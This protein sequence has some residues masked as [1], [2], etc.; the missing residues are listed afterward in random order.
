MLQSP[1]SSTAGKINTVAVYFDDPSYD[2]YPFDNEEYRISYHDLA[3]AIQQRGGRFAIVRGQESYIGNRTFS[4]GWIYDGTTFRASSEPL[5]CDIIYNKGHFSGDG[6]EIILNH[7]DLDAICTDKVRTYELLPN[8][9]PKTVCVAGAEMLPE[10]LEVLRTDR[11]VGKPTHGEGGHDVHIGSKDTVAQMLRRFP[12][13]LQEYVDTSG[14][15]PKLVDGLHD[16]RVIVVNGTAVQAFIRTPPPGGIL[17]NVAQGGSTHEV[18]LKDV[19][20]DAMHIVRCVD[21]Q[22]KCF[23]NRLYSVDMGRDVSGSWFL[24]EL[25]SRPALF[26]RKRGPGFE[27]FQDALVDLLFR[28]TEE[29]E[30]NCK[31]R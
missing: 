10:L 8:V 19:P 9:S 5:V 22:L 13:I 24:F 17:P 16:L 30:N 15:I 3:G 11:V 4:C 26:S 7:P 28:H 23:P 29:R 2:G 27:R 12:Y 6:S 18:N 20:E 14:G 1:Q 21:D 31:K 25:N